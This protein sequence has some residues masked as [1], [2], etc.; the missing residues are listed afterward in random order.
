MTDETMN[1]GNNSEN[2][3]PKYRWVRASDGALAG[4]CKGLGQALGIETWMLRVIWIVAILWFGTG[5]LL[6]LILAVCLPR[7]DRLD[8][9][10]DR[11]LLGVCARIAKRYQLEVGIVR[12]AA[13]LFLLVTFGAAILVYG[14]CYFLVPTAETR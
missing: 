4:V 3:Q 11:K 9:A 2:S 10:L 13:V 1:A 7:V 5:V 8:Q 12:T 14:L 6:Y